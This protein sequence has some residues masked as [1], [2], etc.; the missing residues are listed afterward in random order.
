[1]TYS[2]DFRKKVLEVREQAR[3]SMGEVAKRFGVGK[4]S[5]MRWVKEIHAKKT[6]NKIPSKIDTESLL[7]DI[8]LFP[9]SYQYERARRLNVSKTGINSA[10]KR[11]KITNKKNTLSSKS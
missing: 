5:V 11:L 2:L 9:D 8:E 10:L 6:R 1:M 7:K 4:A 3:L